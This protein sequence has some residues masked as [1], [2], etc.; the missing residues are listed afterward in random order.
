MA[1]RWRTVAPRLGELEP[2]SREDTEPATARA[3]RRYLHEMPKPDGGFLTAVVPETLFGH[4]M[5]Q[6]VR[7]HSALWLKTTLLFEPG[8]VVTNV[9]LLPE[10][11]EAAATRSNRP[12][13]PE[14]NVVLVPISGVH[15]ATVRA[16]A[17]AKSLHPHQVEGLFFASDN[18]EVQPVLNEWATRELGVPLSVIDSPFR[19][20][21]PPLLEE[22]RRYTSRGDTV[23]TVVLGEFLVRRWYEQLLHN[24]TALYIKRFLLFEPRVV[25]TS[26]PYLLDQSLDRDEARPLRA[27]RNLMAS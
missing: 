13:E 6:Y 19:D 1:T 3:I 27:V 12:L 24:Q 16:V 9:P 20:I 26:V 15:D 23:V 5:L 2:I 18:D 17:Y 21:R 25:V 4:S 11:R 7:H 22:I 14:R 10:Q 8:V